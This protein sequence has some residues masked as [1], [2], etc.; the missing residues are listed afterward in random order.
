MPSLTISCSRAHNCLIPGP[1]DYFRAGSL[2]VL[3]VRAFQALIGMEKSDSIFNG[4]WGLYAF[5][6][7]NKLVDA[8]LDTVTKLFLWPV[9]QSTGLNQAS[10]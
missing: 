5:K 9:G 3:I 10:F 1:S 2:N 6:K 8:L 7:S 4:S